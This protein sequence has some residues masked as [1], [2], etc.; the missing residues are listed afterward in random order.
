MPSTYAH[1]RLGTEVLKKLNP[2]TQSIINKNY[3][4]FSIGLHGPDILFYYKALKSN[5]INQV[6][7]N[8]HKHSGKEFFDEATR[9]IINNN[10]DERHI[11]YIYGFICH[12]ALD[13]TCHGYIDEKISQSGISH[14]EIEAEFD[15]ALLIKNG[16]NPIKHKLT[17]HINPSLD[18][19]KIISDFF[20]NITDKDIQ[21]SLKSMIFYNKLLIAPS[22]LKRNIIYSLLRL[23][24]N[25]EEMHGLI[26]NYEKNFDCLDSTKKL[27]QLYEKAIVLAIDL[28]N[29]YDNHLYKNSYLNDIY[30]YNFGSELVEKEE[31]INEAK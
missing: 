19:S 6:G 18:N 28:I 20:S 26:I 31:V 30:K 16:F 11:A 24:G 25:Y 8:I 14:T 15:R 17:T 10:Y 3:E 4:L 9:I 1:Y 27:F 7:F 2:T 23:T 12:F 29:E 21:K 5:P 13:V 22:H